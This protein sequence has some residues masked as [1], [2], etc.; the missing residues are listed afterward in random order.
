MTRPHFRFAVILTALLVAVTLTGGAL[1]SGAAPRSAVGRQQAFHDEMRKLW[2][3]HII[4]TRLTIVSF[5]ADLPDLEPTLDRLL[6]NQADL[7]SAVAPFYGEEAGQA[8]TDLLREHILG[9]VD[10][11][12]A[13]KAA[14]E[15]TLTAALAAWYENGQEIADFLH[16]ANPRFWPQEEMRNMMRDHLDLTLDEA[17]ARLQG[18]FEADIAAYEDVHRQILDMADMLSSG[19]IKQF[20]EKFGG[21]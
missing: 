2:E 17:T 9:A 4:W 8:L 16:Q 6:Q 19:I 10:V 20:P 1:A 11:L 3:D 21:L 12:T 18:D 5:A 14:D 13:A 7:G 15:V